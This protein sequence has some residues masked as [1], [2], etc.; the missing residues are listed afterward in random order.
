MR[1]FPSQRVYYD[2]DLSNTAILPVIIPKYA[3]SGKFDFT[4]PVELVSFKGRYESG[5]VILNWITATET[6][7]LGFEIDRKIMQTGDEKWIT[8]GFRE[9][10]G[11]TTEVQNYQYIDNISEFEASSFSYRLKQIDFDGTYEY[12]EEVLVGNL[13]PGTYALHQNY[14]NPF[15]PITKIYFDLPHRTRVLVIVYDILGNEVTTLINEEKNAGYHSIIFNTQS[16]NGVLSSGIYFYTLYADN[17]VQTKKMV[18]I[19]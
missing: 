6:N 18:L 10:K 15:N 16:E 2:Y 13:V 14:P 8:I 4:I 19:K 7:N 3:G 11:T 9:G 1:T 12:S 5:K 17:F